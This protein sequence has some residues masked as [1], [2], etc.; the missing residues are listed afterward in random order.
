MLAGDE[1][2]YYA[3]NDFYMNN[4]TS[5][6]LAKGMQNV[7]DPYL[8]YWEGGRGAPHSLFNALRDCNIFLD[9]LLFLD[10]Q[11]IQNQHQVFSLPLIFYHL[12]HTPIL[13]LI[14]HVLL[15][16]KY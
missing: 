10:H 13:I 11:D 2:W 1:I 7:S 6:R 4:E 5:F 14:Y 12:P 8:N 3:E 9:N 16:H 15:L